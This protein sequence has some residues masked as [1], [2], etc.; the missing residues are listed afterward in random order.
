MQKYDYNG[1][2]YKMID[3]NFELSIISLLGEGES[4]VVLRC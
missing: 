3:E 1:D 4:G 2:P